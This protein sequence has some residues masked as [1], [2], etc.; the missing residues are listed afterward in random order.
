[1][2]ETQYSVYPSWVRSVRKIRQI[3]MDDTSQLW[4]SLLQSDKKTVFDIR[5]WKEDRP[6]SKGIFLS[7]G[8]AFELLN[9]LDQYLAGEL[10]I[11][12]MERKRDSH[13]C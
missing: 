3:N 11:D 9:V 2:P 12:N 5:L 10:T 13:D 4:V 8:I 7:Y 1:M 6:L